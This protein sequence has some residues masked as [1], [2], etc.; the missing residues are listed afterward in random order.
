MEPI[1]PASSKLLND[2]MAGLRMRYASLNDIPRRPMLNSP[3]GG[4]A[5]GNAFYRD[6]QCRVQASRESRR[7]LNEGLIE[8]NKRQDVPDYE[9]IVRQMNL[10]LAELFY[11]GDLTAISEQFGFPMTTLQAV[12]QKLVR[13]V[14]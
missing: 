5:A 2:I 12:Y 9:K 6:V 8:M 3:T 13:P 7:I 11:A 4:T 14:Q 10:R 1:N